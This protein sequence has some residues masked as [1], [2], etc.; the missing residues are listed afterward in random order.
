ML[1]EGESMFAEE[2]QISLKTS[3]GA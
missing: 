3:K 1:V 2:H